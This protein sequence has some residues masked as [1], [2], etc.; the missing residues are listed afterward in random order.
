MRRM[1][2]CFFHEI[3]ACARQKAQPTRV[4]GST[5]RKRFQNRCLLKKKTLALS[6]DRGKGWAADLEL[7]LGQVVEVGKGEKSSELWVDLHEGV[8]DQVLD[9]DLA[10]LQHV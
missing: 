9:V 8:G 6:L 2:W 3:N 4:K 7:I 5:H 10:I 1:S